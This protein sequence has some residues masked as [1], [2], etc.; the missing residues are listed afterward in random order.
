MDDNPNILSG[1]SSIINKQNAKSGV[2]FSELEKRMVS[3]GMITKPTQDPDD[4]FNDELK[5]FASDL[6]ISFDEPSRG[7]SH[8]EESQHESSHSQYSSQHESP[9]ESSHSQYS[10]QHESSH[11][12]RESSY[13]SSY[14]PSHS[15]P[16]ESS[17]QSSH[18]S[19]NNYSHYGSTAGDIEDDDEDDDKDDD[20]GDDDDD[21]SDNIGSQ[22]NSHSSNNSFMMPSNSY[23]SGGS[24]YSSSGSGDSHAGMSWDSGSSHKSELQMRTHEQERQ[25]HISSVIDD[26]RGDDSSETF[27]IEKEKAEDTKSQLLAQFDMLRITLEEEGADLTRI[28]EVNDR[29][30]IEEIQNIHK[31][32][33]L[34]NDR[35]RYCS[36]AE[37]FVMFGAHAMEE[38]FDGKRVW[39]GR[40]SPDL[41]G[42]HNTVN[43]KLRRM[44]YDTSNLVSGVMQEYNISSGSRILLELVPSMF[45]HSKMRKNQFGSP[46]LY[47]QDQMSAAMND[48]RDI[49]D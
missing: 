18:S 4:A 1:I 49:E 29:S 48:I 12:P 41:T 47:S 15:S 37:E 31:I 25:S 27:S 36:F 42:W 10:S 3:G 46:S 2:D 26:I 8:A 16:R 17:H 19:S 39:V 35:N 14:V 6:N 13:Q 40:Y 44:R 43:V 33:R 34:K 30:T 21:D 28:P 5:K 7:D 23:S 38:I 32:F 9:R 45:L 20:Y 22:F 24:S 11:S